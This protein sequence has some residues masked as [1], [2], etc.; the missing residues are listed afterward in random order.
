MYNKIKNS[1]LLQVLFAFGFA[2]VGLCNSAHAAFLEADAQTGEL[3]VNAV[4]IAV[5]MIGLVV[6][7]VVAFLSLKFIRPLWAWLSRMIS[8]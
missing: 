4:P 8:G 3:T 6:A 2:L 1:R 7:I 5:T